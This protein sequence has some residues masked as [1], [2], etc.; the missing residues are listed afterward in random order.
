MFSSN[1]CVIKLCLKIELRRPFLCAGLAKLRHTENNELAYIV[2]NQCASYVAWHVFRKWLLCKNHEKVYGML[3]SCLT[4]QHSV[5]ETA[6]RMRIKKA[7]V[8]T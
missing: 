7:D 3:W 4:R 1:V 8:T 5:P 6:N 2:H